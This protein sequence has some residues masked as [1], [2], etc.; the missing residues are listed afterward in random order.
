MGLPEETLSVLVLSRVCP[1]EAQPRFLVRMDDDTVVS[2]DQLVSSLDQAHTSSEG[3]AADL[4]VT[5]PTVIRNQRVWRHQ[6]APLMGKWAI[7]EED[8]TSK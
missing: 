6:E 4:L 3:E 5:C 2:F 8:Y 1:P 7:A